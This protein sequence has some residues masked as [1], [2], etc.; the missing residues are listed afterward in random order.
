[1]GTLFSQAPMFLQLSW[2]IH[3]VDRNAHHHLLQPAVLHPVVS[4][5][6]PQ[7]LHRLLRARLHFFLTSLPDNCV[8]VGKRNATAYVVDTHRPAI[9][10]PA[11]WDSTPQC[12]QPPLRPLSHLHQPSW[13]KS[14]RTFRLHFFPTSLLD[15]C[16]NV[17]ARTNNAY[18]VDA[19]R[20]LFH[21]ILQ[22]ALSHPVLWQTTRQ[23]FQHLLCPHSHRCTSENKA[24]RN[25]SDDSCKLVFKLLLNC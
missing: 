21:H 19:H 8:N 18:V 7:G 1:M 24:K 9:L 22:H 25:Q 14:S 5:L 2:T 4:P 17:G 12:L 20:Y 16:V 3:I 10:H 23:R 6:I 15:N 11:M 13:P